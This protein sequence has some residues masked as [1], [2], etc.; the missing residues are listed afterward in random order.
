MGGILEK[1]ETI[2][3]GLGESTDTMNE[4]ANLEILKEGEFIDSL[5]AWLWAVS[6]NCEGQIKNANLKVEEAKPYV[7]LELGNTYVDCWKFQECLKTFISTCMESPPML[8][9]LIKEL[10]ELADQAKGSLN[11]T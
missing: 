10:A 9:D 2:R 6:A 11:N 7:S 4:L 1:A 8:I 5:Q 3:S